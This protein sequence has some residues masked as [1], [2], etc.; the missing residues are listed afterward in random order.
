[1][2]D[3]L[4]EESAALTSC[5]P[6]ASMNLTTVATFGQIAPVVDFDAGR[7][8]RLRLRLVALVLPSVAWT[9]GGVEAPAVFFCPGWASSRSAP[10]RGGISVSARTSR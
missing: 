4:A 10:S 9:V 7:E 8:V 2:T 3:A 5:P 6:D 1:M